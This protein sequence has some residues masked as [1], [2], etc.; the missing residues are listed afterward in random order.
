MSIDKKQKQIESKWQERWQKESVFVAKPDEKKE[1]YFA[2]VAYPYANSV[3]HIGHGRTNTTADI[4]ARYQRLRGKN[5][6]F[7]M[8]F[9]ITGT[10]VLAVADSIKKG[11]EKQWKMTRDA[12]SDYVKDKKEQDIL[13]N[14]F[15]DPMN[16]A[17]FFSSKI[18]ETFNSIGLSIDWTRQFTTGDLEYNKFIEWQFKKLHDLGI[19]KQGKYPILY[20]PEDKNAVGEDDV[21]DGDTEKVSVQEMTYLMFQIKGT[22]DYLVCASLRP[23]SIFGATNLYI[24][25]DMDLVKVKV[26]NKS[27]I[28]S[29]EAKVKLEHQFDKLEVVSEHKGKEFL[30]KTVITPITNREIPIYHVEFPDPNHGTGIVYSSPADS[31]HDYI[32][33]FETLF[34]NKSLNEFDKDPIKLT[35]IT[36]TFDKKGNEIKYRDNIPAFDKLLKYKI[37]NSKGNEDKLE[38]AKQELYKEAHFGATMINCQEFDGTPI[39]KGKVKTEEKLKDLKLGGTFYETS[40]RAKTRGGDPVIVAVLDEQ[41]FLDYSKEE[42]KEKAFAVLDNMSYNPNT[43]RATQKGYL[44]WVQMRPCARKRG[45]GTRLPFDKEWIIEAL[46]D[47]T[48]YQMFYLV[49]NRIYQNKIK[50]ESLTCEFFDYTLLGEGNETMISESTGIK[51][52]LIEEMRH[53]VEYFKS[54][55]LRYTAATHMS[56]HLSFLI[57]HYGL[58]FSKEYWPK[59]ITIGG[60]LIKDGEKISKSKGNGI[61]LFRVK[62]I[63]SADLFRLYIGVAANYDIEMDFKDEEIFQLEKRF[64]RWKSLVEDSIKISKKEFDSFSETNKWLISRFYSRLNNYYSL[65]ED[66]RIREGYVN[67][68]YEFLNEISYHEKRTSYDETIQVFRFILEDYLKVMTPVVPHICEEYNEK[69]GNKNFISLSPIDTDPKEYISRQIEDIENI[70]INLIANI[71]KLRESRNIQSPKLIKIVQAT[72]DRFELFK[73]LKLSL[74]KTKNFKEIMK[75]LNEKFPN[76]S[77]FISKFVPKTLGSGLSHFLHKDKEK[78]YFEEL[79][80]FLE[81]EFNAK[82]EIVDNDNLEE[83]LNSIPGEPLVIIE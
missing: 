67:I 44:E 8:G 66:I 65:M 45:L 13:I 19:L 9:H 77:K 76:E 71:N 28:V 53:D 25:S 64:N 43:L 82:I 7:P 57:Y 26:D 68:L 27:W 46:S 83:K 37:Y 79:L 2:T 48:I 70:G 14:S 55:D 11:D 24:K 20:S 81:E 6:L 3:M 51:K 58:I 22:D 21:K 50:P 49:A 80:D 10:P 23:D 1:K 78:V 4:Y 60:L 39:K 40:R 69:L 73:D 15:E 41:W 56:N 61:P 62:N 33:L 17:K 36:Q 54:F 52:E 29:K 34:P 16:I 30:D 35:P 5:V 72:N 38:E 75:P 63:Y 74:E 42:T 59:N 31:P 47:S 32:N 18:Q 12:I